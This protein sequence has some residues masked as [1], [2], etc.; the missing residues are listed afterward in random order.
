M[1][2]L[3][4]SKRKKNEAAPQICAAS[5]RLSLRSVLCQSDSPAQIRL[6]KSLRENV[7]VI[8]AAIGKL[9]R[10]IGDFELIG[11]DDACSE[12]L[13]AFAA[14][15][16]VGAAGRGLRQFVYTYLDQLLTYGT[17]VGELIPTADGAGIAALYNAPLEAVELRA[18]DNP[19]DVR[20][21]RRGIGA[22][23]EVEHPERITYTL[24]N[25]DPGTLCGNSI[26][27]GL[28]FVSELL[29]KIFESVGQNFERAGNVRFAVTYQPPSGASALNA[30]QRV[31]EIS[32]EWSRAMRDSKRV[33]D[34]VSVGDVSIK[35]IGAD[36]Q[37]LD[38]D[39]PIRH[40]LEQ[41]VSKLSIPPF[42]L[43]FSWSTTERMSA[44]QADILTSELEYY[45]GLLTPVIGWI[46]SA[47]LRMARMNPRVEVKWS[48]ITLQDET[49]LASARLDNARAAEI[50]QRLTGGKA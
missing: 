34:F 32:R 14:G 24:L 39:V 23:T 6:Y 19:L 10:L 44:Q 43:G 50:E 16:R 5:E 41:I 35:A 31:E 42:L 48:L 36:N 29:M 4:S 13:N 25:P 47:M 2:N 8:D 22:D 3:F 9:I 1:V 30:K 33:C 20:I 49:E 46:C 26:L 15:V 21:L 45:R 17:A 11:A 12:A 27:S 7:P 37:V 18:G 40:I 38:C 28:P